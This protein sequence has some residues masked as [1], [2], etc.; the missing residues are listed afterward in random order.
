MQMIGKI[1]KSKVLKISS[2]AEGAMVIKQ[3]ISCKSVLLVFDDVDDHEQLEALAGSPTWFCPGSLII[4]TGKDKQVLRSHRVE[5]HDMKFLDEDKSLELFYSFAFEEKKPS[6][7]FKEVSEEVVKY[8]QGH[9]LAL[10]VLGH[11]LD[12]KT[13]RQWVSELDRLKLHPN[14]KIQSVLR[15]SY[16]GLNLQ[17]LD[18][19]NP[20]VRATKSRK[21]RLE[22]KK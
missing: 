20:V 4:F 8:V 5:I 3:R 7:G 12:G 10:K 9:P 2:V 13:V 18:N 16:D 17:L 1:M 22:T 15:L 6:K 14:E 21:L 19:E 11:F